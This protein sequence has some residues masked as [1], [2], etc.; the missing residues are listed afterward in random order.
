MCYDT[1][2]HIEL[3]RV[4]HVTSIFIKDLL[5]HT[6]FSISHGHTPLC[7]FISFAC[8]NQMWSITAALLESSNLQRD[9]QK[10]TRAII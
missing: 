4:Y 7:T 10:Y 3:S 6:Y 8:I 1:H 2:V 9:I 5:G